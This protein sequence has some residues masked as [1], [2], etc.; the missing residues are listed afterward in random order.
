MAEVYR[1]SSSAQHQ[2][3]MQQQQP[4]PGHSPGGHAHESLLFEIFCVVYR[5]HESSWVVL[6]GAS[7]SQLHVIKNDTTGECRVVSWIPDANSNGNGNAAV[8]PS[9]I[10]LGPPADT[11]AASI[12]FRFPLTAACHIKRKSSDFIRLTDPAG[13]TWGLG[14]YVKGDASTEP[15]DLLRVLTAAV[16]AATAR[17]KARKDAAPA[18]PARPVLAPGSVNHSNTMPLPG[19]AA[20]ASASSPQQQQPLMA[21]PAAPERP[22]RTTVKAPAVAS[23][24]TTVPVSSFFTRRVEPGAEATSPPAGYPTGTTGHPNA[25][26]GTS[27]ATAGGR[28]SDLALTAPSATASGSASGSGLAS[29]SNTGSNTGSGSSALASSASASGASG[30]SAEL[31]PTPH[32]FGAPVSEAYAA[33]VGTLGLLTIFPEKPAKRA[34]VTAT[35][36]NAAASPAAAAAATA[37]ARKS[38]GKPGS[39]HGAEDD[40]DDDEEYAMLA[41]AEIT[42]PVRVSHDV[43]AK[44]DPQTGRI[45]GLPSDWEAMLHKQFAV[46]LPQVCSMII[47]IFVMSYL[48]KIVMCLFSYDSSITL[49]FTNISTTLIPLLSSTLSFSAPATAAAPQVDTI[50]LSPYPGKVP[51]VLHV[52]FALLERAGGLDSEGVFRLAPEGGSTDAVKARI[53]AGELI[54]ARAR[55]DPVTGLP[56]FGEHG[57]A[58]DTLATVIKVWFRELPVKLLEKVPQRVI[59]EL[60]TPDE[61]WQKVVRALPEPYKSTCAYLVDECVRVTANSKKNKMT[62][63][64]LGI[65]IGPNL[66][67]PDE[68]NPMNTLAYS[69]KVAQWLKLAIEFRV[70]NPQAEI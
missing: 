21:S 67:L 9:A 8:D 59:M 32:P 7:W 44:V 23:S 2:H 47:F 46:P 69:Q 70:A 54:G 20:T 16:E 53:D 29:G 52:L 38:G 48:Q 3:H 35:P 28:V 15:A 66:F 17:A 65:V 11:P 33:T 18:T 45:L 49:F 25:A 37:R 56:E 62:P 51:R 57:A 43:H 40:D 6:G 13:T 68:T 31:V 30:G 26:A 24:S 61:A 63:Q 12:L 55:T 58:V 36:A 5:L 19:A 39:A 34:T 14:F 42:S 4:S 64:N 60:T 1:A 50:A 10:P 27:P 41:A 22:R